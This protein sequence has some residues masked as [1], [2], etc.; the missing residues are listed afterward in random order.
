M[1]FANFTSPY[2]NPDDV[3]EV[4]REYPNLSKLFKVNGTYVRPVED[5][6][7]IWEIALLHQ[8]YGVVKGACLRIF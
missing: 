2:Q 5:L 3:P 7:T 4:Y 8:E 1:P 6:V